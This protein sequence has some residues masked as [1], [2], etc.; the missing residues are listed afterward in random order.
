MLNPEILQP[1]VNTVGLIAH[2]K[3]YEGTAFDY[4]L[5]GN[6]GT[7]TGTAPTFQFPGIDLPG[8]DEHITVND[9]TI[10]S[11]LANPLSISAWVKMDTAVNFVIASKFVTG[12]TTREWLL[13]SQ[14][15]RLLVMQI[16]DETNDKNITRAYNTS[17]A[18]LEDTWIHVA[19]VW[20]GNLTVP[21]DT[22]ISLYLNCVKVDDLSAGSG[23]FV[24]CRNTA[25]IV[26]IG[27][28]DANFANGIIDD[29]MI[30]NVEKAAAEIKSIYSQTRGRYGV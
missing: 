27:H 9:A 16:Y 25:A 24:Q 26:D 14:A 22:D 5:N 7:V 6:D 28:V 21:V 29:L 13:Y 10:F 2:Y 19:G 23:N 8:A 20:N 18:S 4:S 30:F 11:P 3:L 15:G 12:D 17:L 1:Q